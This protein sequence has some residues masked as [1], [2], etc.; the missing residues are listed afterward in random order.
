MLPQTSSKAISLER[1][2]STFLSLAPT[3]SASYT[4]TPK[5]PTQAQEPAP[6]LQQNSQTEAS[7]A[8]ETIA[9]TVLHTDGVADMLKTRRSSGSGSD[10]SAKRG[11]LKL[12]PVHFGEGDGDWS[13]HV[14]A[15]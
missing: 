2:S 11:Y 13:K 10:S 14:L 9:P 6:V 8:A 3:T 7:S 5:S 4:P 12:G 15:P 1:Q